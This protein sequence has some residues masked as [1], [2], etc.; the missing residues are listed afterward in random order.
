MWIPFV[1]KYQYIPAFAF[2]NTL[3]A[4][5]SSVSKH[6]QS[7]PQ[8]CWNRTHLSQAWSGGCSWVG[9]GAAARPSSEPWDAEPAA[10][11]LAATAQRSAVQH[12][13]PPNAFH[14]QQI[15][16]L[17]SSHLFFFQ[18]AKQLFPS[19]SLTKSFAICSKSI[20]TFFFMLC[21]RQQ[22]GLCSKKY[23]SWSISVSAPTKLKLKHCV[24]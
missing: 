13:Y 24:H 20:G 1:S 23:G 14:T 18:Q 3:K 22:L 6:L 9:A 5:F 4:A 12:S 16:L 11:C 8:L 15:E 21:Y 10:K 19:F 7:L 2:Q 17:W